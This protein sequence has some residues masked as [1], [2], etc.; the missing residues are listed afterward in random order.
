MQR[1]PV[2]HLPTITRL[3]ALSFLMLPLAAAKA[4]AL[5]PR[6]HGQWEGSDG[7]A[8]SIS[9]QRLSTDGLRNCPWRI[10]PGFDAKT[11]VAYYSGTLTKD[12][13]LTKQ[14]QFTEA[15]DRIGQAEG[16][17][18]RKRAETSLRRNQALLDGISHA[19][20]RTVEVIPAM[21]E[22]QFTGDSTTLFFLDESTVYRAYF[23]EACLGDSF[24]LSAYTRVAAAP[25]TSV[26][27][28]A[29]ATPR[30]MASLAARPSTD[31][32]APPR[33]P[34]ESPD[35]AKP[36]YRPMSYTDFLL[37]HG[38][39]KGQRIQ[40]KASIQSAMNVTFLR[41]NELDSNPVMAEIEELSREDRKKILTL[42]QHV[43]CSGTFYAQVRD[44]MGFPAIKVERIEWPGGT[45]LMDKLGN[46]LGR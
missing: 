4:Q 18:A 16:P 17:Q 31:I 11:C 20:F 45:H 1:I 14:R 24:S 12:A 38:K 30:P 29:A 40:L 46:M 2:M 15:L 44:G 26:P 36:R 19:T 34:P 25:E 35:S 10:T 8:L 6:W 5:N 33:V 22:D 37:D 43:T 39:L 28:M 9:G 32:P 3:L 13:L 42:C 21:T 41:R 27:A 7:S 23:C